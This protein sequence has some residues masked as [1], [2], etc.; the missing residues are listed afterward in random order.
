VE[1]LR[2]RIRLIILP[3]AA[4]FLLPLLLLFSLFLL[5]R[6]HN[7]PGGGFAGGL[8]AA[9]AFVLY[10]VA[11]DARAAGWALGVHPRTLIP[12][13]LLLALGSALL[14]PVRGDPFLSGQW[15]AL[16][17]PGGGTIDLGSPLVFDIGVYLAVVG[18]TLTIILTLAV[19]ETRP[20]PFPR[21][22]NT[23]DAGT[24]GSGG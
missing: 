19:A 8:V 21:P 14:G 9:A 17:L 20:R 16:P 22:A 23:R 3:T 6:G 4:R 15:V 7:E 11:Y 12:V 5:V 13:G 24:G 10:A 1:P 18:V 2:Q